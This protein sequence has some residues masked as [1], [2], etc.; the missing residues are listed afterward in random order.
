MILCVIL[1]YLYGFNYADGVDLPQIIF[2]T[3]V[4]ALADKYDILV[5]RALAAAKLQILAE[6]G[7]NTID[8]P[9]SIKS[10][11]ESTPNDWDLQNVTLQL[12]VVN[13]DALFKNNKTFQK[14]ISE[15]AEFGKELTYKLSS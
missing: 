14:I 5:L 8:F 9:Y 4:Y 10:I 6:V 15:A 13:A 11:Y 7:W 3:Q 1:Q 2:N 12:A